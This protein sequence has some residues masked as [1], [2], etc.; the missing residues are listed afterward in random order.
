MHNLPA[1]I[2]IK[3]HYVA[4]LHGENAA[5]QWH[6]DYLGRLP[7]LAGPTLIPDV[8]LFTTSST[9]ARPMVQGLRE[10]LIVSMVCAQE[11]LRSKDPSYKWCESVGIWD[12]LGVTET[13][14]RM[15]RG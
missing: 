14:K 2:N 10:C 7:T 6:V 1:E 15:V 4:G 3:S 13:A 11:G 12:P 5:V 8:G 9:F